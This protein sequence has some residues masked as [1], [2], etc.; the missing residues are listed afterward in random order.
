MNIII[1]VYMVR[2]IFQTSLIFISLFS[3]YDNEYKTMKPKNQTSLKNFQ[4]QDKFKPQY[5]H[6]CVTFLR[7]IY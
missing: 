5:I 6:A 7:Q 4:I 2:N 1:Y 3:H